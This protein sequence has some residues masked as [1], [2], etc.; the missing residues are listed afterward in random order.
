MVLTPMT[1]TVSQKNN[2][3]VVHYNLNPH[4]P[5]LVILPEMLLWEHAVKWR[6][7]FHFS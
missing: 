5:I 2:T 1:Y 6:F 4:E 7:V 3:D